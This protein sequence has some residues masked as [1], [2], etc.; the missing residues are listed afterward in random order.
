MSVWSAS[1]AVFVSAQER[2]FSHSFL[3]GMLEYKSSS[4]SERNAR[5]G[6]LLLF[7]GLFFVQF[8]KS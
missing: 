2:F 5:L 1:T 3:G 4:F 6:H 7:F 8:F